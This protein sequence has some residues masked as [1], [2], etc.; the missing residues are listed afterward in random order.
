MILTPIKRNNKLKLEIPIERTDSRT[1][2][3][4][5]LY[6]DTH[7]IATRTILRQALRHI[8]TNT[9]I[10][11]LTLNNTLSHALTLTL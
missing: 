4:H 11:T 9:L 1:I 8:L 10:Y 2:L 3:R 7:Y 5:A 6:C